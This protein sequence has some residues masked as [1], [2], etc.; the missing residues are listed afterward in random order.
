MK[1]LKVSLTHASLQVKGVQHMK[2]IA[3]STNP[4][5]A[6]LIRNA[7]YNIGRAYFEGFGVN[8]S[9]KQ[10]EMWFLLAA[11]DG[12]QKGS[13]KSQTVLGLLYSRPGEETFDLDKVY[14]SNL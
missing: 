6:H 10:S 8:Q 1:S 13:L 12:E 7:Q 3:K 4:D 14:T 5:A 11:D 2:E 9:D